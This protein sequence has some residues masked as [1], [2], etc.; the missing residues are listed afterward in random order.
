MKAVG[1]HNFVLLYAD[2]K[3]KHKELEVDSPQEA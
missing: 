2:W 1:L 3:S